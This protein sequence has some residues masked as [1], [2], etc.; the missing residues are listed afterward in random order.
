M[1][2]SIW[3]M[4]NPCEIWWN[5]YGIC[6]IHVKYDGIHGE[7]VEFMWNM[8]NSWRICGIHGRNCGG[9]HL[10]SRE[11]FHGILKF[12]GVSIWNEHGKL[13]QNGWALSQK[14]SIWNPPGMWGHSKDLTNLHSSLT[15][16][17]LEMAYQF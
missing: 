8:W 3:N 14:N 13:H 2:E 9:F 11:I 12:Y 6:G 17:L 10:D 7:Y 1:V 4:W 15:N 5:L 16:P